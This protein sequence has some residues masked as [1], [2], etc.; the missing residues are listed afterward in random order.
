MSKFTLTPE[1][2]NSAL[3]KLT[4]A[5]RDCFDPEDLI[6]AQEAG[7]QSRNFMFG[8]I[9]NEPFVLLKKPAAG[10]KAKDLVSLADIY[11]PETAQSLAGLI[12]YRLANPRGMLKKPT[13]VG[14]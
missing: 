6:K 11:E 7:S 1:Q 13:I 2:I 12:I 4:P 5:W 14:L 3:G 10:F 9:I 8:T